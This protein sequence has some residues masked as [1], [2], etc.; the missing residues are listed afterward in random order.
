MENLKIKFIKKYANLPWGA[1]EEII[2]IVDDQ[3]FTWNSANIEIDRGMNPPTE[4]G[5]K[6]LKQLQEL[7]I[8]V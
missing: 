1:R 7:G 4:I 5:E 6:I 2:A 3:N 8:L